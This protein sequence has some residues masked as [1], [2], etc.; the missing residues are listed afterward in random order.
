MTNTIAQPV[1]DLIQVPD[2]V[3]SLIFR[4]DGTFKILQLADL[5][6]SNDRGNCKD[7]APG[8]STL[9]TIFIHKGM[10]RSNVHDSI[11]V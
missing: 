6:F 5:H 10:N 2:K 1:N 3:S 8:V 9:R 7:V 4:P 11:L